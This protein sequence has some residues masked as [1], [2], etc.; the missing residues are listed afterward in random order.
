M[1]SS[2]NIRTSIT[3]AEVPSYGRESMES[4]CTGMGGTDLGGEHVFPPGGIECRQG[5]EG[6]G[7]ELVEQ[8]HVCWEYWSNLCE[9][10]CLYSLPGHI[11]IGASK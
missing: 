7:K 2:V 8:I 11:I 3:L 5:A 10:G 1:K 4:R 6:E 9:P